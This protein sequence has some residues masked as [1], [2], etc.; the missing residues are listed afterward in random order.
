MDNAVIRTD[1]LDLDG[2]LVSLHSSLGS[3][4]DSNPLRFTSNSHWLYHKDKKESVIAQMKLPSFIEILVLVLVYSF[5]TS[6][7]VFYC[8][9]LAVEVFQRP[10]LVISHEFN[11]FGLGT[12]DCS[13]RY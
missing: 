4:L 2:Y 12:K 5:Y 10:F 13:G 1:V 7:S 8:Y 11:F 3:I 9:K 6:V